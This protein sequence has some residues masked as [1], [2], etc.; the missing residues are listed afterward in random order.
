MAAGRP[1][2]RHA[3][4]RQVLAEVLHGADPIAEVVLVDHLGESLR[5]RFQVAA[6]HAAI[7]RKA[8]GEHEQVARAVGQLRVAQRQKAAD[9][10]QTVLLRAHDAGVG[11]GEHGARDLAHASFGVARLPRLDEPGV[12]GE[13][14][15]IDHERYAAGAGEL[16]RRPEIG[17]AHRLAAERV[18]RHGHEHPAQLF[19][20]VGG[21]HLFQPLQVDLPLEGRRPL[22]LERLRHRQVQHL[23]ARR[24]DVGARGVEVA[25]GDE[26]PR[27]AAAPLLQDPHQHRLGRAA[28]VGRDDLRQAEQLLHGPLE[29]KIALGAGVGLVP[30]HDRR[31]LR[32]T[33]GAG[34]RVGEQIDRHV[35]GPQA[36]GVVGRLGEQPEP[37][38]GRGHPDRLD[39]LDAERFDDRAHPS[40][41]PARL[42]GAVPR[43]LPAG[44][45]R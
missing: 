34:A 25:V 4:L 39:R 13:A 42:P 28:L 16:A 18:V 41:L 1:H 9:V 23:P 2:V 10:G 11:A 40:P 8:L 7:G 5:H 38:G 22:G 35:G 17:Q 19:G 30:A 43:R 12:L 15:G 29:P 26:Q 45:R 33:H 24:L 37:L 31:P 32:R 20:P 6:R 3:E 21:Q 36:E 14:A 27:T 44:S